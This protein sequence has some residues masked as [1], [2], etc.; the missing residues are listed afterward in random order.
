[1]DDDITL[2]IHHGGSFMKVNNKIQCEAGFT[3]DIEHVDM[4]K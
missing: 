2:E 1:M 3:S 4:D